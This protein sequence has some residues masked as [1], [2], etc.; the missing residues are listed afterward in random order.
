MFM[1]KKF[2][3]DH[4]LAVAEKVTEAIERVRILSEDNDY[5]RDRLRN[6]E[7]EME[8]RSKDL[9]SLGEN[10]S[11]VYQE[12]GDLQNKVYMLEDSKLKL[13]AYILAQG[14]TLEEAYQPLLTK[15]LTE[16]WEESLVRFWQR[17]KVLSCPL[18]RLPG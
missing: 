5:L 11:K 14:K 8:Q 7:R 4:M 2:S 10:V 13:E 15:A 12:K 9:V 17:L 6:L 3:V 16:T 1:S 18:P